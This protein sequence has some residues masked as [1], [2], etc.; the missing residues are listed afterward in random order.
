MS[1]TL[2]AYDSLPNPVTARRRIVA[3]GQ[4]RTMADGSLASHRKCIRYVWEYVWEGTTA[5]MAD[6][7][8]ACEAAVLA[9]KTFKPYETATT[10]TVD[11]DPE[12][13][14]AEPVEDSDGNA[15]RVTATIRETT[16]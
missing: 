5:A 9:T 8:T 11:V 7:V 4:T 12:S 2:G 6:V 10:Y 1:V 3:P 15:W 13:Y 14:S 16:A